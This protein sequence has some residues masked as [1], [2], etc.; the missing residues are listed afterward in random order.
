MVGQTAELLDVL[1]RAGAGQ[2]DALAAV[3]KSFGRNPNVPMLLGIAERVS[4]R[5]GAFPSYRITPL[6]AS[7]IVGGIDAYG[8]AVT[9]CTGNPHYGEIQISLTTYNAVMSGGD[10]R[11]TLIHEV[12]H[13]EPGLSH[14]QIYDFQG[15]LT[16]WQE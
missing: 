14:D 16:D 1:N 12:M 5:A 6:R 7:Q 15:L 13:F 2:A 8:Q 4:Q 10:G 3:T 11:Y 9:C